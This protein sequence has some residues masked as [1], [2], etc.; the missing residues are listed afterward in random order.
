M[1]DYLEQ[2]V[3]GSDGRPNALMVVE[4]G[5]PFFGVPL[6]IGIWLKKVEGMDKDIS[7]SSKFCSLLFG[8]KPGPPGCRFGSYILRQLCPYDLLM[9]LV[10]LLMT[11]F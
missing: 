8:R 5:I 6:L 2:E 7:A 11:H 9:I 10:D 4:R 3:D 1:R